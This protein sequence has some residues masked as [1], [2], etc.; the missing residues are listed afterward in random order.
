MST[1]RARP[2]ESSR[3]KVVVIL[4]NKISAPVRSEILHTPT[5]GHLGT[6]EGFESRLITR[7]L[8]NHFP[9]RQNLR[10]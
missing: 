5:N 8:K 1:P 3:L 2:T 10:C 7:V 4:L 9:A 6:C